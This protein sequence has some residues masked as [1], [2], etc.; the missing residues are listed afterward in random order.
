ME[1]GHRILESATGTSGLPHVSLDGDGASARLRIEYVHRKLA[2]DIE[3]LVLFCSDI[4]R[5]GPPYGWT[6]SSNKVSIESIDAEWER[7]VI[8][9]E[10]SVG[11]E[12]KRFARLKLNHGAGS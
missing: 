8:E 7:V 5:Q 12:P 10:V 9:D 6:S 3:Y 1:N 2:P 4:S 11:E